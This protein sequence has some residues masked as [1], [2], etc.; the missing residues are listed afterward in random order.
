MT[1]I[2]HDARRFDICYA[3]RLSGLNIRPLNRTCLPA[4]VRLWSWQ[5]QIPQ[6]DH[7]FRR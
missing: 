1:L 7:D 2:N 5:A 3:G 4:P 6:I